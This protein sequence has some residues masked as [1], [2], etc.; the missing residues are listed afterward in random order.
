MEKNNYIVILIDSL[1][2]KIKVLDAIIAKNKEQTEIIK[3]EVMDSDQFE[4]NIQEKAILIE[5]LDLLDAG[6]E[7]IYERVKSILSV[8]KQ[9]Y[10]REVQKLQ[11]LIGEI[12]SKSMEIQAQEARNK[13]TIEQ[14][15]TK[16]R[17][18]VKKS[19]A[20]QNVAKNYYQNMN[21]ISVTEP[22]FMDRKK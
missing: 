12:T 21:K 18:K 16:L 5:E 6:F 4:K 7:V 22:Q 3:E 17:T 8:E 9:Q 13:V 11:E 20:A 19:K 14:Q 15:F 2:K 1:Q 10:Q